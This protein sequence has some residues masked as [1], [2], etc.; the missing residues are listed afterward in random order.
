MLIV[1]LFF[2]FLLMSCSQSNNY[3]L[4]VGAVGAK[5]LDFQHKML[6]INSVRQLTKAGLKEG[7]VVWDIGCGSGAMTEFI[8]TAVGPKGHVYA[9]DISKEQIEI[10]KKKLESAKLKNVTFIVCDIY[11]LKNIDYP[12]ADIIYSRFLL[13]HLQNPEKAIKLMASLLKAGGVI[14]LHESSINSTIKGKN[15]EK[16]NLTALKRYYDLVT[17]YGRINGFDYDIGNKLP[18]ICKNLGIF[19]KID[20]Y[21]SSHDF[22][23]NKKLLLD[24][25]DEFKEKVLKAKLINNQELRELREELHINFNSKELEQ[26]N[27]KIDQH[28]L[29]LTYQP[30]T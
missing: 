3:V 27:L 10:T 13:M 9:I 4:K 5:N 29:L 16:Y 14:S 18:Q 21:I 17:N 30:N 8:A 28:H 15:L 20:Y 11:N 26:L 2:L 1:Q 6:E 19:S 12:K 23:K 25:F 24:R 22:N 7:M